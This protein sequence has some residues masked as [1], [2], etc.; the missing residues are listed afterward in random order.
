MIATWM[1]Y[2]IGLS[3]AFGLAALAL[4]QSLRLFNRPGRWVWLVAIA[5][6]VIVPVAL[7][8]MPPR[9]PAP[10]TAPVTDAVVVTPI[11]A[12]VTS[13]VS[14]ALPAPQTVDRLAALDRPLLV[15]WALTSLLT[16]LVL[17]VGHIGLRRDLARWPAERV[18]DHAVL[19]SPNV[20]PAVVGAWRGVVVLPAWARDLKGDWRALIVRHEAEHVAAADALLLL[21]AAFAVVVCPWNLALWWHRARLRDAV[22]LDCDARVVR[23]GAD[24]IAYGALLLDVA[25]RSAGI[26]RAAIALAAPPSLLSRRIA[27]LISPAA[28][29]RVARAVFGVAVGGL[30]VALAC[31]APHPTSPV[32]SDVVIPGRAAS[33]LPA[34]LGSPYITDEGRLATYFPADHRH[35]TTHIAFEIVV[36]A[37]GR[38]D[39]SSVK[40]FSVRGDSALV[41]FARSIVVDTRYQPGQVGG[42][43]APVKVFQY[44]QFMPGGVVDPRVGTSIA[45]M[46]PMSHRMG[47][48]TATGAVEF[49]DGAPDFMLMVGSVEYPRMLLEAGI[50]GRVVASFE[51]GLDE[52]IDPKTVQIASST[53]KGFEASV[54]AWLGRA[55][56]RVAVVDGKPARSRMQQEFIF[57]GPNDPSVAH[58]V[59]AGSPSPVEVRVLPRGES[60]TSSVPLVKT[61]WA[62]AGRH[63]GALSYEVGHFDPR[64]SRVSF[65][66]M[67]SKAAVAP[68]ARA[69]AATGFDPATP[70]SGPLPTPVFA[71]TRGDIAY[72]QMLAEAG[73]GGRVVLMF[74]VRPDWRVEP[75]SIR[76]IMS[77]RVQLE[78]AP[79]PWLL[80][81][82]IQPPAGT[83]N[84]LVRMQQEFVFGVMDS[85]PAQDRDERPGT[86]PYPITV[87]YLRHGVHGDS[88]KA[89]VQA[90]WSKG[91]QSFTMG[92]VVDVAP[93]KPGGFDFHTQK[94]VSGA[95][96]PGEQDIRIPR[97]LIAEGV[98]ET[99]SVDFVAY[100]DGHVDPA[101]I[102]FTTPGSATLQ[103]AVR[104]SLL[105]A[106]FARAF[107]GT[108]ATRRVAHQT[109]RFTTKGAGA[110]VH[111]DTLTMTTMWDR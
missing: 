71:G 59:P 42:N 16:A 37:D 101:S 5:A 46:P 29:A 87:N 110:A 78:R 69:T 76:P 43:P 103:E 19:V 36:N 79:I 93:P 70:P 34:L 4:E 72:P 66:P 106:D 15:V 73:L 47:Y 99:V 30:L 20:G 53:Q 14:S 86:P 39:S 51:V 62:Y 61:A 11:V 32:S 111:P 10:V 107:D 96:G 49:Y 23:A 24:P 9:I 52:T 50:G 102:S 85:N 55:K 84:R 92:H 58:N 82:K 67:T 105:R 60:D 74:D 17:M 63:S 83:G 90:K 64:G 104:A 13:L 40:L 6:S 31:E 89:E 22:E 65:T 27:M 80:T 38:V 100:A 97:E 91:G 35:G 109:V 26:P 108:N 41:K 33:T 75:S 28:R 94:T 12:P 56:A 1:L 98:R 2:A 81:A 7:A 77:T 95:G 45:L 68:G 44:L 25:R 8:V 88:P 54:I 48:L 3:L 57:A 18:D 21:L